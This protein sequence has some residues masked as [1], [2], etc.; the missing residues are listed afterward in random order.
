MTI[1]IFVF[2]VLP[3]R[4]FLHVITHLLFSQRYQ[5]LWLA[6]IK[7]TGTTQIVKAGSTLHLRH[8][9]LLYYSNSFHSSPVTS[10]PSGHSCEECLLHTAKQQYT[11]TCLPRSEQNEQIMPHWL[12]ILLYKKYW[13]ATLPGKCPWSPGD[14]LLH[15]NRYSSRKQANEEGARLS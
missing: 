2:T 1:L 3:W 9:G 5:Y 4:I 6:G 13:D 11:K 7:M 10:S 8:L 14:F 15:L 12:N